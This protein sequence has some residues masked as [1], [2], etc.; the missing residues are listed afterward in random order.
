MIL[1]PPARKGA[2]AA[3]VERVLVPWPVLER[4]RSHARASHPE[5][6]C[7]LLAGAREDGVVRVT[8]EIAC[9]NAAS[10]TERRRRFLIEPRTLVDELRS[11]REGGETLVGIYHSHPDGGATPSTTDMTFV[12][13]WPETVWLIVAVGGESEEERAWWLPTGAAAGVPPRELVVD[14]SPRGRD[15]AK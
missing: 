6:C 14:A 9:P 8:R 7:G 11:L 5:E 2:E 12:E 4:I 1:H 3:S 15:G 13:L 10:P